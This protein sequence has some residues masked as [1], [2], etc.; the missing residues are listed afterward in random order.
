MKSSGFIDLPWNWSRLDFYSYSR[1]MSL[2]GLFLSLLSLPI[3]WSIQSHIP[4]EILQGSSVRYLYVHVPCAFTALGLYFAISCASLFYLLWPIKYGYFF[5][6]SFIPPILLCCFLTL[7]S[8]SLWGYETWGCYWIWDARL[9]S[10]LVLFLFL[11]IMLIGSYSRK[12]HL[13]AF[14]RAFCLLIILGFFD[15]LL[16]HYAVLWFKT[17]HQG[18][19]LLQWGKPST[20]APVYAIALW[21]HIAHMVLLNISLGL[22]HFCLVLRSTLSDRKNLEKE[23]LC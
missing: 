12:S 2:I 9:T 5:I 7:L 22:G 4:D 10:F 18:P 17:L 1:M 21:Y 19:G 8:G 20:V 6:V 23:F 16:T 14:R 11:V 13:L 3:L 15:V